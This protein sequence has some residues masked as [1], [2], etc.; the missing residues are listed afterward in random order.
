MLNRLLLTPLALAGALLVASAGASAQQS[1]GAPPPGSDVPPYQYQQGGPAG[2]GAPQLGP[3]GQPVPQA[4]QHHLSR[5][6][7]ALRTLALSPAQKLQI[8]DAMHQFRL[9][10][11]TP[12]PMTRQQLL[13]QIRTVLNP[14]QLAQ[15]RAAMRQPAGPNGPNGPMNGPGYGPSQGQGP[16][17]Q[18]GYGPEP[19][20][21][22]P[23]QYPQP[24]R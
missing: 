2:P 7:M 15:F 22:G 5:M 12:N 13:A 14:R 9:S 1:Q 19:G 8:R 18:P 20:P 23:G 4:P 6:R 21:Q 16:N 10:R 3:D 17:G 24:N 11:Q